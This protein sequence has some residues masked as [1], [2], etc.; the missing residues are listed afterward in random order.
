MKQAVIDFQKYLQFQTSKEEDEKDTQT[1]MSTFPKEPES[2]QDLNFFQDDNDSQ[3]KKKQQ[4]K[5]KSNCNSTKVKARNLL[6]NLSYRRYKQQ[7]FN[8]VSFIIDT[9]S[10]LD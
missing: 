9:L 6:T 4:Q 1:L 5:K 7:D 8:N 10:F 2:Q 3:K